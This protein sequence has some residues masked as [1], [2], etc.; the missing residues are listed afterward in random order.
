MSEDS[1][2]IK[3]LKKQRLLTEQESYDIWADYNN[4]VSWI[5]TYPKWDSI[6]EEEKQ[7]WTELVNL[8][9]TKKIDRCGLGNIS[10]Q[11]AIK[12]KNYNWSFLNGPKKPEDEKI[13][14]PDSLKKPKN[15][16]KNKK[17]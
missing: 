10:I 17:K 4:S 16:K 13:I 9:I 15:N 2:Y 14:E 12:S 5:T 1:D 7:K 6:T 11:D 8:I 3:E